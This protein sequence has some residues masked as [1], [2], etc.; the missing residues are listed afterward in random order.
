M[1]C[2]LVLFLL[3]QGIQP[4]TA[5]VDDSR[6]AFP[7]LLQQR[8]LSTIVGVTETGCATNDAAIIVST[9]IA[10]VANVYFGGWSHI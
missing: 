6:T 8:T 1:T 9:E 2:L 5:H 10:L 7:V 4:G 3:K